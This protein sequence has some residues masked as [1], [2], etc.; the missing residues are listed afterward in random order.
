MNASPSIATRA[1]DQGRSI[2]L[3]GT[4]A[5]RMDIPASLRRR[6]GC[7]FA[8][9]IRLRVKRDIPHNVAFLTKLFGRLY[10]HNSTGGFYGRINTKTQRKRE[11]EVETEFR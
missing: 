7:E 11:I 8:C 9:L 3:S 10:L 1:L 2:R 6:P 5:Y 4:L